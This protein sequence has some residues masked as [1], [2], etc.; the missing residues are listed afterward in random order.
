MHACLKSSKTIDRKPHFYLSPE[1]SE[2]IM[3]CGKGNAMETTLGLFCDTCKELLEM[4]S[5]QWN[6]Q[7]TSPETRHSKYSYSV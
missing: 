2:G 1:Q 7:D 4:S 6:W 3:S 5:K